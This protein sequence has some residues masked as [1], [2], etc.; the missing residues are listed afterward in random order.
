MHAAA[1]SASSTGSD[2]CSRGYR[3][4]ERGLL[5]RCD[6]G[7]VSATGQMSAAALGSK[8]SRRRLA[9]P[10]RSLRDRGFPSADGASRG[11]MARPSP[12]LLGEQFGS[13]RSVPLA[14]NAKA[15]EHLTR[16]S[17][18]LAADDFHN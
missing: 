7:K 9:A 8:R 10:R 16:P 17:E 18:T 1:S 14:G 5:A 12:V 6:T 4:L 13:K 2:G 15:G 11:R 3:A